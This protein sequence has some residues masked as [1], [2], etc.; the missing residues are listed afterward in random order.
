[1]SATSIRNALRKVGNSSDDIV[2]TETANVFFYFTY[3]YF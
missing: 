2:L 3:N 1:M